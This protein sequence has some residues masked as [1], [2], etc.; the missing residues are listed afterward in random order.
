MILNI[1][2]VV[3]KKNNQTSVFDGENPTLGETDNA[4][5]SVNPVSGITRLSSGICLPASETDDRFYL[6]LLRNDI[7]LSRIEMLFMIFVFINNNI[8]K[9]KNNERL[10]YTSE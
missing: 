5:N 4:G 10:G 6:P 9:N 1:F 3:G 2:N 7:P 8:K